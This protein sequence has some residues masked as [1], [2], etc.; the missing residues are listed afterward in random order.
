MRL[1]YTIN[2]DDMIVGENL[3]NDM[4]I[5]R[6]GEKIILRDNC[7]E[8]ICLVENVEY[9]IYDNHTDKEEIENYLFYGQDLSENE[10]KILLNK[11]EYFYSIKVKVKVNEIEIKEKM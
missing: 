3:P 10:I 7:D 8:T 4:P 6:I 11:K 5:P 1:D 2:S 9:T